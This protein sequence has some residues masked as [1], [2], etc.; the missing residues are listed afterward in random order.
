MYREA[1]LFLGVRSQMPPRKAIAGVVV[2]GRYKLL[3]QTC[4][5]DRGAL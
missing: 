1:T 2:V 4:E 5:V 3:E